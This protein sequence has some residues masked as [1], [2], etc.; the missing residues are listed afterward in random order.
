MDLR[1]FGISFVLQLIFAGMIRYVFALGSIDTA[2]RGFAAGFGIGLFF[3]TPW[4]A[5]KNLDAMRSAKLTMIDGGYATTACP[6]IG[7]VLVLSRK[8]GRPRQT[9]TFPSPRVLPTHHTRMKN[10]GPGHPGHRELVPCRAAILQLQ[11]PNDTVQ[12]SDNLRCSA[13]G[14]ISRT[15]PLCRN[16]SPAY[17]RRPHG[18]CCVRTCRRF[19]QPGQWPRPIRARRTDRVS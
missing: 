17:S 18:I 5:I 16:A 8:M 9:G 3:I 1:I 15:P 2:G 14:L 10:S 11:S 4:I 13:L 19:R 12:M 6:I 7:F